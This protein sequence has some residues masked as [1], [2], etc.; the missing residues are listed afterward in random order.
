MGSSVQDLTV[1]FDRILQTVLCKLR[2][3]W[4]GWGLPQDYFSAP[5]PH[6]MIQRVNP[7][8]FLTGS[9]IRALT[10]HPSPQSHR[11][12][13]NPTCLIATFGIKT[14]FYFS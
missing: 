10:T 11:E 6:A 14:N 1:A 13:A 2:S 9:R 12:A 3:N 4:V 5:V 7:N 8:C